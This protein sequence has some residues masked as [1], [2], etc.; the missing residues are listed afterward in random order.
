MHE[1]HLT[2]KMGHI[3]H[4]ASLVSLNKLKLEGLYWNAAQNNSNL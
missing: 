4:I 2:E 3:Q 1:V